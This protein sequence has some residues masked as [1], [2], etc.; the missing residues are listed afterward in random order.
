MWLRLPWTK[1]QYI[2][3]DTVIFAVVILGLLAA[4]LFLGPISQ[5]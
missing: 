1:D 2:G 4:R 3:L 5:W